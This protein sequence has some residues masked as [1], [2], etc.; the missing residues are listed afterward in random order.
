M[1]MATELDEPAGGLTQRKVPRRT[2]YQQ[3]SAD[4]PHLGDNRS[5]RIFRNLP[6]PY[7]RLTVKIGRRQFSI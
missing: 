2:L 5:H 1:A 4:L 7:R 3:R 6:S